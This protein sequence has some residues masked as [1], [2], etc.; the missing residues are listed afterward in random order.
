MSIQ[1]AT[2]T[3]LDPPGDEGASSVAA[4]VQALD[5]LVVSAEPAVVFTSV[6]R[7]CVPLLCDVAVATITTADSQAYQVKW[8]WTEA[9]LEDSDNVRAAMA[10][11]QVLSHNAILTPIMGTSTEPQL[12]YR[13]VLTLVSHQGQPGQG[14]ALLARLVVERA[15]AVI[16]RERLANQL[17]TQ[18]EHAEHLR[19]AIITNRQIGTA[20][21]ILMATHKLTGGQAFDL[22]REVSQ[23]S[24]RK[25][26]ELALDVIDTGAIEL[27]A[28]V[29]LTGRPL[30]VPGRNVTVGPR[31]RPHPTTPCVSRP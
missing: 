16:E 21:G 11:Q 27:P 30:S 10:G 17:V 29:T 23:H 28:G 9:A 22:L 1:T 25:I 8:P 26:R 7:L 2:F 6:T 18:L 4:V 13:G 3:N 12:A 14:R 20:L 15:V 24:H 19:T 31:A 5:G